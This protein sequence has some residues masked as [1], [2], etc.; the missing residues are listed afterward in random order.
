VENDGGENGDKTKPAT[1]TY[2]VML[3]GTSAV[4]L[5]T[6]VKPKFQR[7]NGRLEPANWGLAFYDAEGL[8]LLHTD[9]RFKQGD[10]PTP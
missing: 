6:K 9:E 3:P 8:Q 4:R 2:T 7:G 1:F 5:G 10:C